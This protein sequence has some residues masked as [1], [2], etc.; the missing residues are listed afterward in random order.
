MAGELESVLRDVFEAVDRRDFDVAMRV[1]DGTIQG[2]D[3]ISRKWLRGLDDVTEHWRRGLESVEN[4]RTELRDVHEE[5]FGDAGMVTCWI[6]QDYT[7]EG[8]PQ[9]V[10][11]PMTLVFRRRGDDWKIVLFHSIPLPEEEGQ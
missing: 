10:S 5:T 3:E 9:H 7:Y 8:K 4:L 1:T 6:E 2:V 11:G